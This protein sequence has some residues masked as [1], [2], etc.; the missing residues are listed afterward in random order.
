MK[1]IIFSVFILSALFIA[2]LNAQDVLK[3]KSGS[4]ILPEKGDWAVSICAHPFLDYFGQFL[5]NSGGESPTYDFLNSSNY[6][7]GKYFKDATTAYRANLRI[8]INSGKSLDP[9]DPKKTIK[10]SSMDVTLGA[11]IEKRRGHT[12][13]QGL[14]GA[15]AMINLSSAKTG[16]VKSPS[17]FGLGVQGFIGAEYFI[18]PKISIG[19]EYG[20]GL[21]FSSRGSTDTQAATS[22]FGFDTSATGEL[23]L[24]LHF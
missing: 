23:L 7:A 24:T 1:K 19:G 5:S 14:Y 17:G 22:S 16:D 13:L 9:N 4:I 15:Q 11:G 3:S 12:R 10:T 21:G 8:G 6:I 2:N 20:W 18:L